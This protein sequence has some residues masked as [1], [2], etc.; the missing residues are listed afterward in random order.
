MDNIEVYIEVQ[1]N[2]NIKYESKNGKLIFDRV[3]HTPMTYPYNYGY[4]PGTLANDGDELDVM[5]ITNYALLPGC[6]V[7]TKLIGVLYTKDENGLDEKIL[8]VP[9][10][11]VDPYSKNIN[12]ISDL[13]QSQLDKIHFFFQNYK[14]LEPNKCVEVYEFGNSDDAYKLYNLYKND[15]K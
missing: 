2:S 8:A 12:N 4:I 11:K 10:T 13:K 14:K 7:K 3:L 15:G 5:V 6:Y 1:Q 9:I